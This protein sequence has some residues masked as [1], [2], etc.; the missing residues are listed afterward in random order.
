MPKPT[1]PGAGKP[2]AKPQR[3][4]VK[5]KGQANQSGKGAH[6]AL[7]AETANKIVDILQAGITMEIACQAVGFPPTTVYRWIEKGKAQ[8]PGHPYREFGEAIAKARA[9]CE[10]DLVQMIRKS[11]PQN[12]D[13][14]KW[15][16]E[17]MFPARYGKHV[18]LALQGADGGP[19]QVESTEPK[20]LTAN[21]PRIFALPRDIDIEAEV[22]PKENVG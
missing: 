5:F 11:A 13:D 15:L 17:R 1:T 21:L 20:Q 8:P 22:Q 14:A 16:L 18:A 6:S 4:R 19:I 12:S 9:L 7:T 10:I 2:T 3:I